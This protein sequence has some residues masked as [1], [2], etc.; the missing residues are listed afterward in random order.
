M[1]EKCDW[2]IGA[3]RMINRRRF[4]KGCA[5]FSLALLT[6][7]WLSSKRA[8]IIEGTRNIMGTSVKIAAVHSDVDWA[9]KAMNV[10]FEEIYKINDLMS[11]Y[12]DGSDI[13]LLNK[14][15]YC[16]Y[17]DSDTIRVIERASHHS[18]LSNGAFNVAVLPLMELWEKCIPTEAKLEETLELLD[19]ENITI[20]GGRI[21][22]KK[23]G[24]GLTLGGIA[25]GYAVD[26]AI[27]TLKQNGIE[28]AL[29]SA[30]G[31]MRTLG[32]KL[33][34]TPWR[35]ALRNP[36]DKKASI[37]TIELCDK[38]VATSG[39]YERGLNDDPHILDPRTG[40]I[41]RGL[42]SVTILAENTIDADA[43]STAVFVLGA[44]E[45]MRLVE[46]SGSEAL[47]ITNDGNIV[48]SSG[49]PS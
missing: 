47:I 39:N 40:S 2:N 15:G 12:K 8:Y 30:G 1:S 21:Q 34:G 7:S 35:V 43:L 45:G 23:A 41:I 29:V 37:T 5:A 36:Q 14:N 44:E 28:H 9:K 3:I 25:K 42:M 26:K 33:D 19:P 4:I 22:F 13:R 49:F 32:N 18:G 10:S 38:A 24:M 20:N 27:E 6:G 16:D 31:D 48:R 17:A 46:R 11:I